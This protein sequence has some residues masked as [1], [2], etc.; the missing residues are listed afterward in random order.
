MLKFLKRSEVIEYSLRLEDIVTVDDSVICVF[1]EKGGIT[2]LKLT[3]EEIFANMNILRNIHPETIIALRKIYEMD[4]IT[5]KKLKLLA[6]MNQNEFEVCFD[7]KLKIKISGK[8]FCTDLSLASMMDVKDVIKI[9]Y[10]TAFNEAFSAFTNLD[11]KVNS[12]VSKRECIEEQPR[13]IFRI[14]K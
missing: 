8:D 11:K 10:N 9:I 2:P 1:T 4:K 7:G 6:I 12:E 3:I 5:Q 13:N 14:V